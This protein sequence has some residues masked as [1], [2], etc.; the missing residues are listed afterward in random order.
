[1]QYL[2]TATDLGKIWVDSDAFRQ[3]VAC[4][5]PEGYFCQEMSFLGDKNMLNIYLTMASD[6]SVEDKR[7]LEKK[8]EDLFANSGI[9][10]CINWLVIPPH[11]NPGKT[12][13][14]VMPIFWSG[15]AAA[16][17][18]LLHMGIIGILW[19]IFFGVIGYGVSWLLLT[20][21]GRKQISEII[22][23]FRR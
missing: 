15:V 10:T 20:E 23:K 14:W 7:R 18:A 12:P 8:L 22:E 21:N 9:E 1:M 5:L 3:I 17:S 4:R 16:V 11:E 2:W 19:S 13:I 6:K